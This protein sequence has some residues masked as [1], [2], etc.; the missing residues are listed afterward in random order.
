MQGRYVL[1]WILVLVLGACTGRGDSGVAH[2]A[3]PMPPASPE[4]A[5]TAPTPSATASATPPVTKPSALPRFVQAPCPFTPA[6]DLLNVRSVSCGHVIVPED[7][8]R[9]SGP[10]IRLA[11]AVFHPPEI[12]PGAPPLIWLEGGPGGASL[13]SLGPLITGSLARAML[14]GRDLVLF[15]QRGT[16]HS[17]PSLACPEVVRAKY[18]LWAQRLDPEAETAAANR[19]R[20]ECRDRLV[21]AGVNLSAYTSAQN[22]ADVNAIRL[23]L[24]YETVMLYGASYG[25]RLA[26]TV[27]RDFPEIL[28]GVVLDSAVPPQADLYAELPASAQRAF[29]TLFAGCAADPG[30]DA[31]YPNLD[32]VFTETV[33]R[34][35]AEPPTVQLR[36]TRTG[37]T[38]NLVLTGARFTRALFQA[39]YSTAAIPL[40][41]R[42]IAAARAGDYEPFVAAVRDLL[43]YDGVSWGMYYSVQCAEEVPF[44]TRATVAAAARTVRPEIV[45]ALGGEG[46]FTTC[47]VWDVRQ[48]PAIENA[49]VQSSLPTLVLAGQYD[50]V[51]PPA[52]GHLVASTLPNSTFIEFPGVGHGAAFGGPCPFVIF[53][54]FL[55]DPSARPNSGCLAQMSGP[56]WSLPRR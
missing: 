56:R 18:E 50:P 14:S 37:E 2:R 24:G 20:Q 10:S 11:V 29:D 7:H 36:R 5:A 53:A 28:R 27:M 1:S 31:A 17:L 47:T 13:D 35:D 44:T 23:A 6:L 16:G 49:P 26:L 21:R 22:A 34:L 8:A 39:L 19:A 54:A 30:C 51:T 41:P 52:W 33:A 12:R 15:D 43:L 55:A 4:T 48:A 38:Y 32:R 42:A 3:T 9:P 46:I 45:R 40:L 25:A